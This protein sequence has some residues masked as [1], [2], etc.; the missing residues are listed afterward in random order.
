MEIKLPVGVQSFAQLR[1]K[2]CY[3]VDK[4]PFIKTVMLGG[5]DVL[6]MTR[7]R[8]FGK[9][10]FMNTLKTFLRL[11][12]SDPN[13]SPAIRPLFSG[14]K[15]LEDERFCEAFM[16]RFPVVC[17]TLSDV[18]G[19]TFEA[20]HDRLA[21]TLLDVASEFA[22]LAE[23]DALLPWERQMMQRYL[24][25]AHLKDPANIGDIKDFLKNLVSWLCRHFGR[26][27]RASCR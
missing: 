22:F 10:L 11:D 2:D 19:S 6:L 21:S 15:I 12:V 24:T 8:R 25:P 17:I 9:S 1:E 5:A 27:S 14:L 3:Y 20:A 18:G 23:S 13:N 26:Q 7:P 16:G 4:T